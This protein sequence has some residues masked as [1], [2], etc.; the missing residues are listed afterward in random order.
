MSTH[1]IR[2]SLRPLIPALIFAIAAA[3]AAT[4]A[5]GQS[6]LE[7]PSPSEQT[8]AGPG[9]V[10]GTQSSAAEQLQGVSLFA[11]VP[12][13]PKNYAKHD[14][15]EVIINESSVEKMKQTLDTKKQYDFSAELSK[16]PSLKR[17]LEAQL[18]NGGT[19]DV[20][21]AGVDLKNS[22]KFKGEG[23]FSRN[24]NLT[25]RISAKVVDVKPNGTVAIEARESREQDE[26]TYTLVLSGMCRTEDITKQNTIQSAQLADLTIK[27]EHGGQ[28]KKAGEK[29]WIPRVFEAIFNF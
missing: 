1:A 20:L 16:F 6:L 12:P 26:E 24:D 22:N 8:Q 25:A 9:L 4:M 18:T 11:V 14:L 7:D 17:L 15:V 10:G 5:R 2:R 21:P 13:K 29:G 27:I 3:M 28:V 19:S 23:E